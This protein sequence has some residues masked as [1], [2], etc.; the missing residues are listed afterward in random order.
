MTKAEQNQV[1]AWRLKLL[2]QASVMPKGSRSG[3]EK[4]MR[5]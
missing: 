5:R 2:Q 1:L 3:Q 4:G